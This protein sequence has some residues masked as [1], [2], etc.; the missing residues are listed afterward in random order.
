MNKLNVVI[1]S[2][3]YKLILIMRQRGHFEHSNVV[4]LACQDLGAGLRTLTMNF[5]S[6]VSQTYITGS[7][8]SA[9]LILIL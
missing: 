4:S 7:I 2:S 6:H 1:S 5:S 8:L 3:W 9:F